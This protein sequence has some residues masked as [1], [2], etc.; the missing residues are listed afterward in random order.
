MNQKPIIGLPIDKIYWRIYEIYLFV[1][2][3]STIFKI[4]LTSTANSPSN[5]HACRVIS[6]SYFAFVF[7]ISVEILIRFIFV[8]PFLSLTIVS[9]FFMHTLL[10]FLLSSI[11][12]SLSFSL[13]VCLPLFLRSLLQ[14]F[15]P[16]SLVITVLAFNLITKWRN[17]R[18]YDGSCY[19]FY[20]L[21]MMQ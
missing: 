8:N 14:H 13:Y 18:G 11:F 16:T 2:H 4:M 19:L 12:L 3:F 1:R 6:K 5:E 21:W 20:S 9:I 10:L 7:F 17:K 15:V